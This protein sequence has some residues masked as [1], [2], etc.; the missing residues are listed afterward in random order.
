M[1][2]HVHSYIYTHNYAASH[3]VCVLMRLVLQ[4]AVLAGWDG[5]ASTVRSSVYDQL[6]GTT[7]W[8]PGYGGRGLINQSWRDALAGMSPEENKSLYEKAVKTGDQGWGEHGRLTTYAGTGVGLVKRVQNAKEIVNEIV[9]GTQTILFG[10]R[11]R[12]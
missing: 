7:D 5:G 12:M 10:P 4:A 1:Y 2:I 8:P 11:S 9:S 6:R 3:H